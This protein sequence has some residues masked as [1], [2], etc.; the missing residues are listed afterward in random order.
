MYRFEWPDDP[1]VEFHLSHGEWIR[2]LRANQFVIEALVEVR[3]PPGA[4]SG[5]SFVT[6]EWA[7]RWPCEEAWRARRQ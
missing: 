2:L 7:S 5:Y 6:A 1:T 3:P 4:L